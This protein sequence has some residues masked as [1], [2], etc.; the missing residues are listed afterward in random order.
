MEQQKIDAEKARDNAKRAEQKAKTAEAK[1]KAETEKVKKEQAKATRLKNLI[2]SIDNDNSAYQF[3]YDERITYFE[4]GDYKNALVYFADAEFLGGENDSVKIL[5]EKSIIGIEADRYFY[6]GYLNS[7]RVPYLQ[8]MN[9]YVDSTHYYEQVT[10]IDR[11]YEILE[12]KIHDIG[13]NSA[14]T[15]DLSGNNLR[16]LPAEIGQL[17][18]LKTLYL[19]GNSLSSVPAEIGQLTNLMDLYLNSN[20]LSSVPAEIGQLT[21]LMDLYLNSNSLS[22]VPAEIGQLTNLTD[23]YLSSNSLSSVPAEIGQLTNLTDLYL[24][25]YYCTFSKIDEE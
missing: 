19:S 14:F 4:K 3:L 20:S 10:E 21:N 17:D 22:S 12:K 11:I 8:A 1:A 13:S 15:L 9:I 23:L 7:A 2:E 5:I 18:N 25:S 16:S 24:S 6:A